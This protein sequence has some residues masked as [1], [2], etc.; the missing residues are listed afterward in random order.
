MRFPL[1][2]RVLVHIQW[3]GFSRTYFKLH[4][5]DNSTRIR[6]VDFDT[7]LL[8]DFILI[9]SLYPYLQLT[10]R[11]ISKKILKPKNH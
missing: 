8:S 2:L 4:K 11:Y 10:Y 9:Q 1:L 5:I 6:F 3:H 7:G